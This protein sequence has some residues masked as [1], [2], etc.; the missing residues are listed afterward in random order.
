[1]DHLRGD[2]RGCLALAALL[3]VGTVGLSGCAVTAD[4]TPPMV[5]T[6][7]NL[8][9]QSIAAPD[10]PLPDEMSIVIEDGGTAHVS[11]FP[12]G[13]TT[14]FDPP[15]I[16]HPLESSNW[17]TGDATWTLRNDHSIAITYAD[18]EIV[19]VAET[20]FVGDDDWTELQFNPCGTDILWTLGYVCGR[21]G[22]GGPDNPAPVFHQR[23]TAA[24]LREF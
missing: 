4:F 5:W 2:R 8:D 11:S 18:S 15:A 21:S 24:M 6:A 3:A 12:L 10:L 17:F 7:D 23:C 16:C 14:E 22:Y 20:G 19:L 1:M 13:K 9:E